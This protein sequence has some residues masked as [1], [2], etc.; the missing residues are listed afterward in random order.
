MRLTDFWRRMDAQFGAGYARSFAADYRITGLGS[1]VD[2]ALLAG[3]E[4][5]AVWRAICAE[6]DV[7][8]DLR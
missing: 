3:V 6:F 2:E 4:A 8:K 5:K 1:T 7:R